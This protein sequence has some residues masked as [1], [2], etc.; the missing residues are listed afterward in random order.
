MLMIIFY[1][2]YSMNHFL[3]VPLTLPLT[4]FLTDFYSTFLGY[5]VR[6]GSS[7]S[8]LSL[9]IDSGISQKKM[10]PSLPTVMILR[11]SGEILA[12][13]IDPECPSPSK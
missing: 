8:T 1:K 10:A 6:V 9:T 7:G 13:L 12:L 3:T 5:L 11:W 2:N 4:L